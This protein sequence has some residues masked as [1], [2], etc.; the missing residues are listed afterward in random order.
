M[1]HIKNTERTVRRILNTAAKLVVADNED[2]TFSC[3]AIREASNKVTGSYYSDEATEA[4]RHYLNLFSPYR[5]GDGRLSDNYGPG[6]KPFGSAVSFWDREA[7]PERQLQRR[8]AL[9]FA[10]ASYEYAV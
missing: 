4:K 10:A 8:D 6:R 7:S 2:T 5:F 1:N 3:L 9:L